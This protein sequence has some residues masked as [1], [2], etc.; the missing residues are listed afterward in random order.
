MTVRGRATPAKG[1]AGVTLAL[2]TG[3]ITLAS[4]ALLASVSALANQSGPP[5]IRSSPA[6]K[7]PA[8]VT[9]ERL[10]G[11]L[12]SRNEQ[13]PQRY[14]TI[15]SAYRDLGDAYHI[16]WDYAF[17][18][19][20]IETNYLRFKRGDGSSGDVSASQNNF[21]GIG[22]TGGGV[23]GERFPDIRTGV[24]A[25]MQHL[26]AYSG[27]KVDR[28]VAQRTREHQ[29]TIIEISRKLGR[30]VHFGDLAKR[31]AA[32]RQYGRSIEVIADSF[33]RTYCMGVTGAAAAGTASG[34]FGAPNK[35]GATPSDADQTPGAVAGAQIP[36][37]STDR[38]AAPSRLVR[39]VWRR[40]DPIPPAPRR[41]EP[42]P[43]AAAPSTEDRTD[44]SAGQVQLATILTPPAPTPV[45]AVRPSRAT[46]EGAAPEGRDAVI[47]APNG[48]QG[49]ARFALAAQGAIATGAIAAPDRCRV[50]SASYGGTAAL[51]IRAKS[52][53]EVRLTA[54]TVED[55]SSRSMGESYLASHAIGGE[56]VGTYPSPEQ[57]LIAARRLC[58]A[59]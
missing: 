54:L 38:K 1:R 21:A 31:W 15:A 19:M 35:L 53:G 44:R 22:A 47:D 4:A 26:V 50:F 14:A 25:Q 33:R 42:R 12:A 57:A 59:D 55:R 45:A 39:T 49:A 56:V 11:F 32:D 28:P 9:P 30:P 24:A 40:G 52:D 23:P 5:E 27:E 8:C 10:M 58:P 37:R 34:G 2:T 43:V 6:N 17:Y 46:V 51:L 13:L 16:R 36:E 18:Q 3:A 29:D 41:A 7:V 20:V 48:S